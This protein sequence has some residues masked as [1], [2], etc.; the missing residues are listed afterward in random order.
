MRVRVD[1]FLCALLEELKDT[2]KNGY[3]ADP[4]TETPAAWLRRLMREGQSF[5]S[6]GPQRVL[7]YDKVVAK[8]EVKWTDSSPVV[9]PLNRT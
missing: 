4:G 2:I 8:A 5:Y 1:T 3:M 7:F 6:Q 9:S